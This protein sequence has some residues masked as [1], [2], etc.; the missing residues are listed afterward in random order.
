[1]LNKNLLCVIENVN[2]YMLDIQTL[3]TETS[4]SH[5]E[6]SEILSFINTCFG[7]EL[8]YYTELAK[9]KNIVYQIA[10]IFD[11]E[12]LIIGC[13]VDGE[14]LTED[15]LYSLISSQDVYNAIEKYCNRQKWF[16]NPVVLLETDNLSN[17]Y[18]VSKL[19]VS[20]STLSYLFMKEN[21]YLLF[22]GISEY[23]SAEQVLKLLYAN[24][25][26]LDYRLVNPILM[27][28]CME[29]SEQYIC[30]FEHDALQKL[31]YMDYY[32]F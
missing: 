13:Q 26:I 17:F 25:E 30:L 18:S 7:Y 5:M 28:F 11:R 16:Y 29:H 6:Y 20:H 24:M 32:N 1:M 27:L 12:F 31:N 15:K 9:Y 22:C 4:L 10:F 23:S 14:R 3:S 2:V 19:L 8:T 21:K